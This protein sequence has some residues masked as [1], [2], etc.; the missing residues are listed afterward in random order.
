LG[1]IVN[2]HETMLQDYPEKLQLAGKK[3]TMP[4]EQIAGQ[5]RLGVVEGLRRS[6]S[7]GLVGY[8]AAKRLIQHHTLV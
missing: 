5:H 3:K 8:F 1:L 4:D 2:K 6:L 7:S